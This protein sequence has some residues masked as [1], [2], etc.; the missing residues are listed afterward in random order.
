MWHDTSL[1]HHRSLPRG[2][3]GGLSRRR[4]SETCS[5]VVER[6]EIDVDVVRQSVLEA[7][8]LPLG[9][10]PPNRVK[11]VR[12][13]GSLRVDSVCIRTSVSLSHPDVLCQ[14]TETNVRWG[15]S[16]ILYLFY[17]GI[18]V[19]LCFSRGVETVLLRRREIIRNLNKYYLK[20]ETVFH[21]CT[22]Y[23]SFEYPSFTER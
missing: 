18:F 4:H 7:E 1:R 12:V 13:Y 16:L 10:V 5:R 11:Y 21:Y 2:P 19:H 22:S 8:S 17:K 20:V 6:S 23:P 15:L 3:T 9:V 14:L